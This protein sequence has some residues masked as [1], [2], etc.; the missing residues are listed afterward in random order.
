MVV[1][2]KSSH[3]LSIFNLQA[4]ILLTDEESTNIPEEVINQITILTDLNEKFAYHSKWVTAATLEQKYAH[5]IETGLEYSPV[6]H[7]GS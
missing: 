3:K 6:S 1:R 7:K 5:M 2:D 4:R